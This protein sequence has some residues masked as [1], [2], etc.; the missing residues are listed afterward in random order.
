MTKRESK[1]KNLVESIWGQNAVRINFFHVKVPLQFWLILLTEA[2]LRRGKSSGS[3]RGKVLG[4]GLCCGNSKYKV[5]RR[6]ALSN[7]LLPKI[8]LNYI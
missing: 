3:E 1:R 8:R 7:L 4:S 2:S 5:M 6:R